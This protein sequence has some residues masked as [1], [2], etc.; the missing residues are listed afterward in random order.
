MGYWGSGISTPTHIGLII[1]IITAIVLAYVTD[2]SNLRSAT[3]G[4]HGAIVIYLYSIKSTIVLGQFI[5]H[6]LVGLLMVFNETWVS[7]LICICWILIFASEETLK[8][9]PVR[10]DT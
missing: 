8:T 5:T 1:G 3:Y 10:E 4:I 2:K 7:L 6:A 9:R